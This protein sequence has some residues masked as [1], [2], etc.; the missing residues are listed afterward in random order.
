MRHSKN[1]AEQPYYS[2]DEPIDG[3]DTDREDPPISIIHGASLPV[4]K[5]PSVLP[6]PDKSS[7]IKSPIFGNTQSGNNGQDILSDYFPAI[8]EEDPNMIPNARILREQDSSLSWWKR[9]TSF[10][11]Q[12]SPI[13][14]DESDIDRLN[15]ILCGSG[16]LIALVI[17]LSIIF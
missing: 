9:L 15:L 3:E 7:R 4:W 6:D 16:V 10:V 5:T 12:Y 11:A 2:L 13:S 1:T 8:P 17:F 14:L